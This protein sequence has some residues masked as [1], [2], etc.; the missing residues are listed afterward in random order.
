MDHALTVRLPDAVYKAARTMADRLGI[1]I[2]RLVL[3]AIKG[4]AERSVEERLREA[5]DL[6]AQ[7]SSAADVEGFFAIQAEAL[8]GE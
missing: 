3:E 7:D 4:M 8:L 1:S 5:Y 6:L 2:N